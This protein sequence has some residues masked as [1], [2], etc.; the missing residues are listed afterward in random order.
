MRGT[1]ELRG[2]PAVDAAGPAANRV[3]VEDEKAR[4][5]MKAASSADTETLMTRVA[6]SS[7]RG[8]EGVEQGAEPAAVGSAAA[9]A[10]IQG[11][12]YENLRVENGQHLPS[13][14]ASS[15]RT[16]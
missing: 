14:K 5:M 4:H 6:A 12:A 8:G 13:P 2:L 7:R 9:A 16:P 3:K 15:V 11:S 10:T 1:S